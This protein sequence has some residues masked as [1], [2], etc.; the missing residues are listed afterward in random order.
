MQSTPGG[1][2]EPHAGSTFK[3]VA[4][5][6]RDALRQSFEVVAHRVGNREGGEVD[7]STAP[8]PGVNNLHEQFGVFTALAGAANGT[9]PFE[10][11]AHDTL[12]VCVALRSSPY[13][14]IFGN[15]LPTTTATPA[16]GR[17]GFLPA[18]KH[19]SEQA[20]QGA[21]VRCVRLGAL[22]RCLGKV[23]RD[24]SK[25]PIATRIYFKCDWWVLVRS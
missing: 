21:R 12:V 15:A 7:A 25:S 19:A 6:C 11:A 4:K 24:T 23:A 5:G 16:A 8:A 13:K 10:I 3:Q 18:A 2:F 14:D 9:L 20:A 1:L 17:A 22:W